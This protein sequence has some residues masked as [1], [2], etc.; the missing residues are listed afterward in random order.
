MG[1]SRRHWI[2]LI[3]Y[4]LVAMMLTWPLALHFTSAIPGVSGDSTSF[5]W[6][7]GWA[8]TALVDLRV[9]PFRTDFVYYPLGGATQLMWAVSLIAFASIPLQF[10]IGLIPTYNLLYLAATVLT[11]YGMFLL[12]EY[13][14][15]HSPF[16][17]RH[18]IPVRC[19]RSRPSSSCSLSCKIAASPIASRPSRLS[20]PA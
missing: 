12:T 18:S 19:H 17:I 8:K 11:A 13:V 6:A 5:L 7:L 16:A 10:L 14:L 3:L 20:S 1:N 4:A 15:R 2:V 9:N